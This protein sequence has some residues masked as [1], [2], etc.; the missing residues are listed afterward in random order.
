MK[1]WE[2][3]AIDI[4]VILGFIMSTSILWATVDEA[5]DYFYI[6]HLITCLGVYTLAQVMCE[7]VYFVYRKIKR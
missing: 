3:Y 5:P 7:L 6:K 2:K 4:A 1:F